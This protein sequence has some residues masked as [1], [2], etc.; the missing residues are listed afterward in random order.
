[1]CEWLSENY[2]DASG[3]EIR[4]RLNAEF[5]TDFTLGAMFTK[6]SKLGLRKPQQG[7]RTGAVRTVRWSREP[8]MREWMLEHDKGSIPATIAAFE[9]RFGFRL[10]R[11][12]VSAF[13][14]MHGTQRRCDNEAAHAWNRKPIG[15][16]RDTGKGYVLVKVRERP[17]RP[18]SKDNW[19]MKH[20][21]AWERCHG[22]KLPEGHE[23]VFAN[24]DHSDYSPENLVAVPKW[25]VGII[26]GNGFDGWH[27]R[28]TLELAVAAAKLK[29]KIVDA[30]CAPRKCAVCG[31]EFAP[32]RDCKGARTCPDCVA[33]GHKACGRKRLAPEME[34]WLRGYYPAHG[35]EETFAAWPFDEWKPTETTL[36]SLVSRLGIRRER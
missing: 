19:E 14:T 13:R 21:L 25:A 29:R 30:E 9:E 2:H 35:L 31:R 6:A 15:Y 28:Q 36:R 24:R 23:V 11:T 34:E 7:P 22:R 26:N 3:G 20:V 18:G 32:R 33:A 1:M 16:E 8:E 4:D 5:G 27:D 17:T 12:Q 10:A